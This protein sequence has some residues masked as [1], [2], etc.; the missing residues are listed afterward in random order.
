MFSPDVP[1][2]SGGNYTKEIDVFRVCVR[3]QHRAFY[4]K[5]S[6]GMLKKKWEVQVQKLGFKVDKF[7]GCHV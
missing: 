5:P 2:G 1:V 4:I 3:L 7:L 6:A